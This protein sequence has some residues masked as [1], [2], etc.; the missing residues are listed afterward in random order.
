MFK[1]GL[2]FI[3]VVLEQFHFQ[4]C[5]VLYMCTEIIRTVLRE[6]LQM[7]FVPA[8]LVN[9]SGVAQAWSTDLNHQG[10]CDILTFFAIRS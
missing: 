4:L 9:E 5:C 8:L 10:A 6:L 1:W 7:T 2:E 3:L